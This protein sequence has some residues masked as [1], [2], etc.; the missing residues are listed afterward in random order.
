MIVYRSF[1]FCRAMLRI[2]GRCRVRPSVRPSVRHICVFCRNELTYL[3]NYFTFG[4]PHHFCF[5]FAPNVMAILWRGPPNGGVE[6]SWGRQKSRFST[7]RPIWLSDRWLM[8]RDQQ[9]RRSTVQWFI[10]V[11]MKSV[12]RTDRRATA[13]LVYH[14]QHGR[15]RQ[16][17]RDRI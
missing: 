7:N 15:L 10:A 5:F 11:S 2:S 8:K 4:Q 14:S 1:S 13:N 17:E 9:A 16:R 6:C 12:Y 3:Q